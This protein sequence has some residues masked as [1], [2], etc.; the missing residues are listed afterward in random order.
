M[1]QPVK[2]VFS[3]AYLAEWSRALD[4]VQAVLPQMS[5][6]YDFESC[7]VNN[8]KFDSSNILLEFFRAFYAYIIFPV[9]I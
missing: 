7:G 4:F 3:I 8:Q 2:L 9:S 5:K 6:R 1:T